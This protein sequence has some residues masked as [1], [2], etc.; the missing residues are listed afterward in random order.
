M[1][2]EELSV[3]PETLGEFLRRHRE[4]SGKALEDISRATR[5]SK[6]YLLAFENDDLDEYPE[7]P[8]DRGFLRNYA[9]EMGLDPDECI[10]RYEKFRKA[11]MP[12][13]IREIK[14]IEKNV[15]LG[16]SPDLSQ[17][18]RW[19]VFVVPLVL[20]LGLVIYLAVKPG[21]EEVAQSPDVELVPDPEVGVG[22]E[23]IQRYDAPP[24]A[25]TPPNILEI[26]AQRKLSL[27]IR[28]DSLAEQE[29]LLEAGQIKQLEF[30]NKV[31]ID[32]KDR[33]FVQLR[34]NGEAVA[35]KDL[36]APTVLYNPSSAFP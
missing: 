29:I 7:A 36:S 31:S 30:R 11:S 2:E 13:Q 15:S 5:V 8:F 25:V 35:S 6:R 21:G 10:L 4:A 1:T 14:K 16:A 24:A 9:L 17:F 27:L 20:I 28:V 32:G 26:Q 34:L 12:T 23:E 33:A 3:P 18:K 22:G 19:A